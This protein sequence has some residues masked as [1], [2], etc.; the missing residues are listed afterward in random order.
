MALTAKQR[1]FAEE[2]LID[3]NATQA[4]IRAGYSKEAARTAGWRCLQNEE[5]SKLIQELQ[6]ERSD[7][8]G[9]TADDILQQLHDQLNADIAQLFNS[10]D[11]RL[12]PIHEWPMIFRTGLVV[13]IENE[14]LYEGTGN[15]R[16]LIGH[17]RKIKMTERFNRQKMAAQHHLASFFKEGEVGQKA[18]S[19]TEALK[20]ELKDAEAIRPK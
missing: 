13:G 14:E 2:Y 1:A 10:D 11:G 12:K 9:M 6:R 8:L 15:K 7:R 16:T 20:L 19:P 4:A 18:T 3:L 5:C 17:V